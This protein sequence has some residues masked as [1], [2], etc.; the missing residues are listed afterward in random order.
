MYIIGISSNCYGAGKTTLADGL[1]SMINGM[2]GMAGAASIVSFASPIKESALHMVEC[3]AGSGPFDK[4]QVILGD[5]VTYRDVLL[6]LGQLARKW[7]PDFWL[8]AAL[9]EMKRRSETEGGPSVFIVDDMRFPN[10]FAYIKKH[11]LIG[12]SA[13]SSC[14]VYLTHEGYDGGAQNEAEGLLDPSLFDIRVTRSARSRDKRDS[15]VNVRRIFTYIKDD[16]EFV[17]LQ[18]EMCR[19][20]EFVEIS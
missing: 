1:V 11:G 6:G 5:N 4:T 7:D 19:E 18:R 10:E 8:K 12:S 17:R 13:K 20:R 14:S 2:P 3:I 16:L 9:Y 15:L